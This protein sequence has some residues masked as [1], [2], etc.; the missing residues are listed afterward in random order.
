MIFI[1]LRGLRYYLKS[2]HLKNEIHDFFI[3]FILYE[4]FKHNLKYT[5]SILA[6]YLLLILFTFNLLEVSIFCKEK[7]GVVLIS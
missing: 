5:I 4:N 6:F 1:L 7:D 3:I 2:A